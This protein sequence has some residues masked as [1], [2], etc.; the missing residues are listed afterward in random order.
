[1]KR[2]RQNFRQPWIAK[3]VLSLIIAVGF[4]GTSFAQDSETMDLDEINRQLNNPLTSMWSFVFRDTLSI[5]DG[6]AVEDSEMNNLLNFQPVLS[7][8]LGE[9]LI[10]INRPVF[11]LVT[12][13]QYDF[14]SGTG[15]YEDH[16]TGLGDIVWPAMVGPNKPRGF[17]WGVGPTVIF[18]TATDD[19]LGKGKWQ[20]GPAGVALYMSDN[21]VFGALGQQWWS[22]AGDDD[23]P[24]TSSMNVQYFIWRTLPGAWQIGMSPVVMVDWKADSDNRWT[25]PVG[26]GIGKTIKL[27]KMPLKI[28]LE[29]EYAV[30]RPDDLGQTWNFVLQIAPVIPSPFVK[31]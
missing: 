18:P 11:P 9:D 31:R 17:I 10:L 25:I 20:A 29:V 24:E 6:D 16:T 27:G 14:T 21:W 26:L 2:T 1:M 13:P 4:V 12:A 5:L 19:A 23:R 30:V 22:F 15:V 3:C 8:P 28:I 7:V